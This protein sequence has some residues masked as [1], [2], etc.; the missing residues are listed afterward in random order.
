ML[1]QPGWTAAGVEQAT[2]TRVEEGIPDHSA[3]LFNAAAR[4]ACSGGMWVRSKCREAVRFEFDL[5]TNR[6]RS[7]RR[8]LTIETVSSQRHDECEAVG[9]GAPDDL[10]AWLA[11]CMGFV[12]VHADS[13]LHC[14]ASPFH[15]FVTT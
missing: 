6:P 7:L 13:F 4:D 14:V 11:G 12:W 5:V 10:T 15:S 9:G 3:R 2:R 1:W 8:R